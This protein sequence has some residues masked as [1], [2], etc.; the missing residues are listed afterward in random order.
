M[1]RLWLVRHGPTHAKCMVGWSDLPADLSDLP[2]LARLHDYLPPAAP[3]ISSD[4]SRAVAT[5][6]TLGRQRLP[7]DPAL[8]EL[9]FG[10]WELRHHAELAED[11][12]HAAQLQDF[13]SKPG[14]SRAPEG[15]AWDDMCL[16]VH[17]ALDR[18]T[19]HGPDV[20]VVCHFGP[21]LAALQRAN[22]LST[23]A[24]FAHKIDNLSVTC[25]TL[26]ANSPA[27]LINHLP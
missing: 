15:E 8:R 16:R 23:E 17:T 4:L 6:D 24:V 19:A 14:R 13:W 5:A 12:Q 27:Q 26:G 2:R 18:L 11:P 22:Q 10:A 25:V 7:H 21:I 1:T 9:N 20:I 3:V